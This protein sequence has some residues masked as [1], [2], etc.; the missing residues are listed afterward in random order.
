MPP[1]QQPKSTKLK[2][3][4]AVI[5]KLG[6][7]S[8]ND[9]IQAFYC[10]P[11]AAQA[12]HYQPGSTFGPANVLSSWKAYAPSEESRNEI[13][14][15]IT[16]AAA[17]IMIQESTRAY[18]NSSLQISSSGLNIPY[19]TTEFGLQQIRKTYNSLLPCL[20]LLLTLLLS[21]ENDYERKIGREKTGKAEM[22]PK[23]RKSVI[24]CISS[25]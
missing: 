15:A 16:C 22:V 8:T 1:G 25:A 6:W 23:V 4:T 12:L 14:Q 19:L 7:R 20:T 10:F 2:K 17:D 18:H 13:N 9:F 21:A 3:T 11:L 24:L 5:K